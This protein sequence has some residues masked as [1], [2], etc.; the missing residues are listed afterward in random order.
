VPWAWE[1]ARRVA[2]RALA[3]AVATRVGTATHY[4]ADYVHPW[5]APTLNKLTQIGAHIFYRWKGLYGEPSAFS[6]TYAGH[7]PLIDEA[8]FARPRLQV[9]D[10]AE[11]TPEGAATGPD[12]LRTVEI[13]GHSRVV[14][15]ASLGGRRP[16]TAAD[17][18]AINESLAAFEAPAPAP[19]SAPAAQI[20]VVPGATPMAVEEIGRPTS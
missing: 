20:V 3:G 7:E 5:W 13:D 15:V 18:A 14:G 17:I 19:A 16:P 12:T 9:A 4:H 8:R 10:A 11:A 6:Q 2:D 1:R